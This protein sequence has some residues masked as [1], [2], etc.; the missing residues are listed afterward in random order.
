MTCELASALLSPD[1]AHG[2][3]NDKRYAGGLTSQQLL[4]MAAKVVEHVAFAT[5]RQNS[6]HNTAKL[7]EAAVT[8]EDIA[9][10]L[11]ENARA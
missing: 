7:L 2:I 9:G 8:I 6:A 5:A 4:Q 11:E 10:I 3:I 1:R